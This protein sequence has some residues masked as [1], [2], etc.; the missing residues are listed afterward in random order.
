M[1][2][3]FKVGLVMSQYLTFDNEYP[4]LKGCGHM[5]RVLHGIGGKAGARF[6]LRIAH[7]N[8]TVSPLISIG[9]M[10]IGTTVRGA[11]SRNLKLGLPYF[12]PSPSRKDQRAKPVNSATTPHCSQFKTTLVQIVR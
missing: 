10:L 8:T 3:P 2:A 4:L 6:S 9:T 11:S 1:A 5:G 7:L 12:E